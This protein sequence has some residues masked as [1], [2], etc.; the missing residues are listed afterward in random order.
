MNKY[1]IKSTS[2][3]LS[4]MLAL[5]PMTAYAGDRGTQHIYE[6]YDEPSADDLAKIL[7]IDPSDMV[8]NGEVPDTDS[9]DDEEKNSKVLPAFKDGNARQTAGFLLKNAQGD[10]IEQ[11]PVA[12]STETFP[13]K[14]DLR[15]RGVVTPV[16]FQNPW[17]TCW[18]FSAIA[19]AETSILTSL[20]K[21][22]DE[23]GLDLS[24][25]Q[26]TY[27]ARTYMN[28]GSDQD[29]EGVHMFAGKDEELL[30]T[31]A[32]MFTATS[33]FSSGIG[34]VDEETVPYRGKKSK[35]EGLFHN[36]NYSADDD[37][38]LPDEYK[39]VQKYALI[40]S[41]VLPSPAV[42]SQDLD[43]M[44]EPDIDVR[45]AAYLGYDQ[46]ATDKIKKALMDGKAVSIAFAADTYM[47]SGIVSVG[48][49]V[50][51]NTDDNKWTH[52]TY[53]SAVINHGVT[54]VGWDDT[55]KSTD[56]LDHSLDDWSDGKA[57]QPEGDGAWIVKN[58]WG[59]ETE[60]FPNRFAWGIENDEGKATGYFYISYYDR[61]I[62]SP[63]IFDFDTESRG[64]AAGYIIDQYSYMQSD[65]TSGWVAPYKMAMANVFTA[66]YDELLRAVSCETNAEDT[67]VEFRVYLLND[68]SVSP[69]DGELQATVNADFEYAGYH[70]VKVDTPV[71]IA[72]GKKYAVVVTQNIAYEG[73]DYYAVSTNTTQ[74]SLRAVEEQNKDTYY[75]HRGESLSDFESEL[76][77]YYSVGVVNPGESYIYAGDSGEWTDFAKVI[78]ELK[79]Y[80]KYR[81]YEFDNFPIKAYLDFANE[82]DLTIFPDTL[83]DLGYAVPAGSINYKFCAICLG[84]LIVLILLI[85]LKI[86][87]FRKIRRM[88]KKL[89]EQGAELERL[90]GELGTLKA[91]VES[92]KQSAKAETKLKPPQGEATQAQT[93]AEHTT[94]EDTSI[95]RQKPNI[96]SFKDN[97]EQEQ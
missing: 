53:D 6:T 94:T 22:Y 90:S 40:N 41:D 18:G 44:G 64:D 38:T 48:E 28:D 57:H 12:E 72:K 65:G 95:C 86:R 20:N 71:H 85:V 60:K 2:V 10:I 39:F 31:G 70:R 62:A 7:G 61:S 42:Y 47:P 52:Y 92:L 79:K 50:Y 8:V 77:N 23:T 43:I 74:T 29:G 21:T 36:M 24:E 34:V 51:L 16:K 75:E 3:I 9:Q 33:V 30:N 37:W 5:S 63:E 87:R 15:D 4:L 32:I 76:L 27:F 19:A 81:D 84:V 78:P 66:E 69:E 17:G 35:T 59:A 80:P 13:E 73:K 46:S 96:Q 11:L 54:I 82:E 26:L 14:F 56:F 93:E 67:A 97:K 83:P 89:K 55:I 1:I 88:K 91:E 45:N 58:S 49:P 25:H 68:E